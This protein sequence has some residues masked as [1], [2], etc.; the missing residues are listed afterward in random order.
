MNIREIARIA[1]VSHSTVSRALRNNPHISRSTRERIQK[2]AED[3][4]YRPHPM[5]SK[6]MAQLPH[7]RQQARSTIAL[8]TCW[9]NWERVNFLK[10]MHQGTL[11]RADA[12]GF[13]LEEF[14]LYEYKMSAKRLNGVLHARN[15]EGVIIFPFDRE[16]RE[17][18]LDWQHFASVYIGRFLQHPNLNRISTSYYA[19]MLLVLAQLKTLG[20]KRIALA[21]TTEMRLRSEDAYVAAYSAYERDIPTDLRIPILVTSASPEVES[22]KTLPGQYEYT[23]KLESQSAVNW[24]KKHQA[25]AIISN[26][27]PRLE[28]LAE[29]GIK[30]PDDLGY[31]SLDC[32][33]LDQTISGVD[34]QPILLG[35]AAVDMLTAHL[36]RNEIGIPQYPKI[37]TIQSRWHSGKTAV[38][39]QNLLTKASVT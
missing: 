1:G 30:V 26:S 34:Q 38:S 39:Q 3:N 37:M 7:V 19:N 8:I 16:H 5:V 9:K 6:L 25:D 15:I 29:G 10:Q 24:L 36:H 18:E 2:I 32:T 35:S 31:A 22:R 4:G 21:L 12:L 17:L 11:E 28:T 23:D 27:S 20:Y 13:K 14:S 33:N